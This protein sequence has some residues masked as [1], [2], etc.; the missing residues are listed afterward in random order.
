[1]VDPEYYGYLR[2][3]GL[4]QFFSTDGPP[5]LLIF[6]NGSPHLQKELYEIFRKHVDGRYFWKNDSLHETMFKKVVRSTRVNYQEL[7]TLLKEIESISNN[8]PLNLVS[9]GVLIQPL[10]PNKLLYRPN[11]DT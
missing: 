2:M 6:K 8:C 5:N 1:M 9:Y 3:E 7:S 11:F 10:T 4:K